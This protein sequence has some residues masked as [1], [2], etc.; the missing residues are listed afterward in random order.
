MF[1]AADHAETDQPPLRH[2]V[3]IRITA[4]EWLLLMVLAAIQFTHI[5]D[6]MIIMPLGPIFSEEMDLSPTKFGFVV[7]AYTL[8][9]GICGLFAARFLD[10]FDRKTAILFLYAGFIVGTLLCAAAPDYLL[11]LCARAIAGAFGGV[12][13][14]LVLAIVGDVFQDARRG[15]A[16]GI[17]MSAFSVASIAGVPLGLVLAEAFT[18]HIPFIALGILSGLVLLLGVLVL[19]PLRGHIKGRH[20]HVISTWGML[21]HANHLRAFLLTAALVFSSFLLAPPLANFLVLNVGLDQTE[22]PY[23]YL[24]GGL[25]TL[26][27]MA[28]FGWLSDRYGKLPVFRSLALFTLV[29]ILVA[30][31]LEHGLTLASVLVITTIFFVTTSGRMVPAM[32]LITNS[33][34]PAQRGSFMSLNAAVQHFA[35]ALAASLGGMLLTKNADQSLSGYALVGVLACVATLTS[36]YLAGRL[37]PAAGGKLAPDCTQ[38]TPRNGKLEAALHAGDSCTPHDVVHTV[39]LH[40]GEDSDPSI[41]GERFHEAHSDDAGGDRPAGRDEPGR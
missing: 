18:W 10:R 4:R 17:V 26:G 15:T 33:C 5:V 34:A 16:T 23:M 37:R 8:S 1:D 12:V 6:F 3:A 28:L 36:V 25:A 40:R 31:N 20:V 38:L 13:A 14:A 39:V 24:C 35:S 7:G 41:Q 19:P 30:T 22:L 27:T 2:P 29:P 32:A 21:A 11:L 9:A